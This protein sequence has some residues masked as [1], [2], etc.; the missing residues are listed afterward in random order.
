MDGDDKR[1][2]ISNEK[3][4]VPNDEQNQIIFTLEK[5]VMM[6]VCRSIIK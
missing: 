4:D 5:T 2:G 1:E 6:R 3:N